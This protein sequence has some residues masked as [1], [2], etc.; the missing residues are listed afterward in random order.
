LKPVRF[1]NISVTLRRKQYFYIVPPLTFS[2]LFE[3]FEASGSTIFYLLIFTLMEPIK[4]AILD[5]YDGY[6][7]E[8]MRCIKAIT[9]RFVNQ[10]GMNATYQ[11]FDV[12]Q[13]CEVPDLGFDIYI[14]SGGPGNPQ[15]AGEPWE[16]PFFLLLDQLWQHNRQP[17]HPRKKHLFL[18]CHSF[19]M[20]CLHWGVGLVCKRRS[21]SFGIF[22]MTKTH[23]GQNEPFF[24]ALLD[25]FYAV[26]S[27]DFQVIEPNHQHLERI[28]AKILCIEK[29]R[30]HVA[31][32]ERAIMAVRFSREVFGTQFHPEADAEGM[33]RHFQKDEKRE[34]I[35]KNHG[36]EKYNDMV[37]HLQDPDKIMLT[38]ASIIPTFLCKAAEQLMGV[39]LV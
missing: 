11:I 7:N 25:P 27:R 31:H 18:I 1:D 8:G 26:D 32:L 35:I 5:M 21:T 13:K 24:K 29:E 38:E 12:R 28:G 9:E 22:P 23:F 15:P 19:Q 17:H 10:N 2:P 6:A 33:L 39:E 30:P 34:G 20:A 36:E 4:I 37:A 3:E 16:K 14:S